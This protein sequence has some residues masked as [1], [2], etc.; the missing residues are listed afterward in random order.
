MRASSSATRTDSRSPTSI[1]RRSGAGAR[2]HTCSPATRPGTHRQ[3]A[4]GCCASGLL[5]PGAGP[6]VRGRAGA[7][8]ALMGHARTPLPAA[9]VRRRGR[10]QAGSTV[11]HRPRRQRASA[12]LRLLRGG[13]GRRAAAKPLARDEAR[14]IAANV[15]KLPELLR[16]GD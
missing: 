8:R 6:S 9:M 5:R 13:A 3:A 1:S 14:R 4:R 16:R 2:L 12:G 11:L 15:D 7:A 10:L